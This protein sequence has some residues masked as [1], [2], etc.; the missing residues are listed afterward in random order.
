MDLRDERQA[1]GWSQEELAART[2]LSVRTIQRI[3]NGSAPGLSSARLL[4]EALGVDVAEI[5]AAGR[6]RTDGAAPAWQ[7]APAATAV[8]DGL[9]GFADF[10]GRA[11]RA[12]Y[13]WFVLAVLLVT[14][15]ATALAEQLGTAV[16]VLFAVPLVAAGARR[17]HDT[18]RSGWWQL[19]GLVPFGFV[20]PLVLLVQPTAEDADERRNASRRW[21]APDDA[22]EDTVRNGQGG[23][24]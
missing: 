1:R 14:G 9:V 17:L 22:D 6:A 8:R 19:F 20:V 16:G 3:E 5:T 12:D 11:G 24:G 10:E 7:Q 4:A 23:S 13:W 2:G 21:V 15:A 18:R